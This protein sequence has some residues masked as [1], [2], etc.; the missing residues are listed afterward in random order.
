MNPNLKRVIAMIVFVVMTMPLP[1]G[2]DVVDR[3]VAVVNDD[4]ITLSELNAAF[5]PFMK[6][7]EDGYKGTDKG[8]MVAEGKATILSRMVDHVLI[9]Q[10]AKKSGITIKDEEVTTVLKN[11]LADRKATFPDLL[12]SLEKDG[13][14]LDA[15]K[16]D[17]KEQLLRQRLIRREVQSKI[18]VSDEE[19]GD[20]YQ[21]HRDDYE[22]KEAVRVKQV[23]LMI[24]PDSTPEIRASLRKEADALRKRL[25]AGESFDVIAEK[26]SQGPAKQAGGDIGFIERGQTLPEV[27]AAAFK[28]KTHELS[29][30]IESSV[31]FHLIQVMDKKGAGLKPLPAVRQE[32]I[33]KI[34]DQKIA[35][36]LDQWVAEL[37]KK[38]H[39]EIKL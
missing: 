27:E 3:I 22:G 26:Y 23:L 37:R 33:M 11:M 31:G 20:Y 10:Q 35:Q 12:K 13:T 25:L 19:V 7:I 2:G 15:Y 39:V 9:E 4:I 17:L 6:R 16:K 24:P 1:A 28:M 30:V 14:T 18:V 36:R 34:E 32:I 29:D 5:A 8:K 21:Q 38:A